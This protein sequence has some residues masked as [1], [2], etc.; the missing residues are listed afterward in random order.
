[1]KTAKE[2]LDNCGAYLSRE[3]LIELIKQAQ[4]E[5]IDETIKACEENHISGMSKL[6]LSEVANQ[7]KSKLI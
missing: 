6:P 3:T 4:K 2:I 7:L 1:M 5:A